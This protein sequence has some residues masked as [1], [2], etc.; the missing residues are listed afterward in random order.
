MSIAED[1]LD[2]MPFTN[3][4]NHCDLFE[5]NEAKR[6]LDAVSEIVQSDDLNF[7][8]HAN[9]EAPPVMSLFEKFD[10]NPRPLPFDSASELTRPLVSKVHEDMSPRI[11]P[12][13]P[14]FELMQPLTQSKR[15]ECFH[16]GVEEKYPREP[17]STTKRARQV[18]VAP[19]PSGDD[20]GLR[21]DAASETTHDNYLV[22]SCS[23]SSSSASND[24]SQGR[25][26]DYQAGQWSDRFDEL[27][28]F[29]GANGHCLVPHNWSENPAL[30]QWVKR[31]RYQYKLK[32]EGKHSTLTDER[33]AALAELGFVWESHA[34]VWEERFSE[35]VAF[36][37]RHGHCR[38][39]TSFPENPSLAIW[40]KCQRRQYSLFLKDGGKKSSMTLE[41]VSRLMRLGFVWNPR[42]LKRYNA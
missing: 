14:M 2:P 8:L 16:D 34:N 11:L 37:A 42:N 32:R 25:F 38:V 27:V 39:P 22:S 20:N 24:E 40:V 35:L 19:S 30:A 1:F 4:G 6:I 36:K 17:C 31:Q 26:R 23:S 18:G 41:R 7:G 13:D 15:K 5:G 29:H 10:L 28:E 12:R 9:M 21:H 33:E 3:G